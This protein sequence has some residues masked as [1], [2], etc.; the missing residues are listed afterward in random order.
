MKLMLD[1][2]LFDRLLEGRISIEDIRS[3]GTPFVTH[4]QMRELKAIPE[5]KRDKRE[6]LLALVKEVT[7]SE[8]PT[9]FIL[10]ETPL[11]SGYLGAAMPMFEEMYSELTRVSGKKNDIRDCMIADAA[12]AIGAVLITDDADLRAVVV[13]F[14][15]R[16]ISSIELKIKLEP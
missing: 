6:K 15:C 13:K 16:A 10:G 8:V 12:F 14:G 1:S 5:A 9:P 7:A 4:V 11:G 3:A 2:H